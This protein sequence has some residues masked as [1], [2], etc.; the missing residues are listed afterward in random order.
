MA[1]NDHEPYDQGQPF[2]ADRFLDGFAVEERH[3]PVDPD[4]PRGRAMAAA[5]AVWAWPGYQPVDPE[6]WTV[7]P[8][9]VELDDGE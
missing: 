9:P 3:V 4:S 1:T 5:R 8:I 6:T 7:T 2:A